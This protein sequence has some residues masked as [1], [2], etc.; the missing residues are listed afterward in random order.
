[1]LKRLKCL[2]KGHQFLMNYN[3][4]YKC[5]HQSSND[6]CKCCKQPRRY[7]ESREVTGV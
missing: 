5:Y 7:Y 1:M 3:P 6:V 4:R 2:I